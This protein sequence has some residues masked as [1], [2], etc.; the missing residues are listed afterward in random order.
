MRAV[1]RTL[2]ISLY[3]S[4]LDVDLGDRPWIFLFIYLSF[5]WTMGQTLDFPLYL[6]FL[7]LDSGTD[8]SL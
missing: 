5:I 7:D 8:Y 2:D 4:F 1:G 3:L 6:S